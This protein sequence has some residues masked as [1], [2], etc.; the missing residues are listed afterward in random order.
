MPS[1]K[2]KPT[3][4]RHDLTSLSMQALYYRRIDYL[5]VFHSKGFV[6]RTNKNKIISW[7]VGIKNVLSEYL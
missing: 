7:L 2:L 6:I 5:F 3:F 4:H 1:K